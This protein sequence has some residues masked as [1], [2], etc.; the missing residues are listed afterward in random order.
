MNGSG[1]RIWSRIRRST[2]SLALLSAIGA[3]LPAASASAA[4][5]TYLSVTGSWINPQNNTPLINE[6]PGDPVVTNGSPTSIIRWGTTSGTPQSGYDYTSSIPPPYTLPGPIPFFS[7]GSFSHINFAVDDPSL[8]SVE[9]EVVLALAVDGVPRPPMTFTFTFNHEET[10]NDLDPCPYPTQGTGCTDRVTI[11]A[12]PAPATFVVD[13]IEYTLD[14][15]FLVNG[16]VVDE[17]ITEEG[18]TTNSSGL[19]G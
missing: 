4:E 16:Q 11:V 18:G 3:L 8:T 6:V 14:M 9:L 10:P 13:G 17:Y 19:V 15:N 12:S 1:R 2:G 5:I 7:L